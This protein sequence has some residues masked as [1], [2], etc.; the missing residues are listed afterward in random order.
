LL[1]PRENNK[2]RCRVPLVTPLHG[3]V[4]SRFGRFDKCAAA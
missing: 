3:L 2:P 1:N 4:D